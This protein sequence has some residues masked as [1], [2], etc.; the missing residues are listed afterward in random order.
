MRVLIILAENIRAETILVEIILA[1]IFLAEI[2]A[3]E[4]VR[5]ETISAET[6]RAGRNGI[7]YSKDHAN[8]SGMV[9]SI[10]RI[11]PGPTVPDGTLRAIAKTMPWVAYARDGFMWRKNCIFI[12][13]CGKPHILWSTALGLPYLVVG[14]LHNTFLVY[15]TTN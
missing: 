5:T 2:I 15:F 6:I 7:C 10:A 8:P 14:L 3:S 12:F 1:E 4:I 13:L 11:V 9:L